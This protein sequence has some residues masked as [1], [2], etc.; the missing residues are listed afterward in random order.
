M[1]YVMKQKLFSFGEDFAIKDANG[2]DRFFVD[3]K[4]FSLGDKLVFE[5][6]QGHEL[7]RIEQ[8]LLSFGKAYRILRDGRPVAT[9]KKKI[10]TL[11][12]DVFD[13]E[14][15]AAG[16]LDATGDFLDREYQ[17]T[18]DGRPVATVSKRFFS[19]TDTYGVDIAEGEDDVLILACA[20]VIDMCSHEED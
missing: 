10:F 15:A 1:R 8:K 5:D 17:F 12:R 11:F 3:G 14:D 6:M 20:V 13:V 2:A 4:A 16:D 18:R 9:V 19:W 7:A